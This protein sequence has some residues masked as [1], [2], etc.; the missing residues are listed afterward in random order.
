MSYIIA[1]ITSTLSDLID[2][3]ELERFKGQS[4]IE[5]CYGTVNKIHITIKPYKTII[6]EAKL[7]NRA[8]FDM[9]GI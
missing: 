3:Y 9:L 5:Y 1:D 6:K 7:N 2:E 8:F 4:G